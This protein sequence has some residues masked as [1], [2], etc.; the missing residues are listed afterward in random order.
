MVQAAGAT[1]VCFDA[2]NPKLKNKHY[3]IEDIQRRYDSILLPGPALAGMDYCLGNVRSDIDAVA[4]SFQ[5]WYESGNSFRRLRS[6]KTPIEY[7]HSKYTL[8]IRD[9][10]LGAPSRDSNRDIWERFAFEIGATVIDDYYREPIHLHDRMALYAGAKMN[11]GVCNGPIFM[12]S[13]TEYP[14]AMFVNSQSARNSQVRFGMK[15]GQNY[16]W[17]LQNQNLIWCE[18]NDVDKLLRRFEALGV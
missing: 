2:A 8:T 5:Q 14:V 6:I 7:K 16:P 3:S 13:L 15:I 1:K 18:D 11:F 4:A 9:N 10:D 12:L 17:M